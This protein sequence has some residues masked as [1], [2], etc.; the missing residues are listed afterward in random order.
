MNEIEKVTIIVASEHQKF[1]ATKYGDIEHGEGKFRIRVSKN[2]EN[3]AK[4]M[5]VKKAIVYVPSGT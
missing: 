4:K 5:G 2:P 3:A 1:A